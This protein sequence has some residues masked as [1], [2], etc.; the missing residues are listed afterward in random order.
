M[1]TE[2]TYS[3]ARERKYQAWLTRA[4]DKAPEL[5]EALRDLLVEV[6]FSSGF[7]EDW[8]P[9]VTARALLAE[10]DGDGK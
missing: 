5:V 4:K 9:A 10:I 2:E 3:E 6:D 1:S 7:P 8:P